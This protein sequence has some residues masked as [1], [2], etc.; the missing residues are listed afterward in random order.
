[1]DKKFEKWMRDTHLRECVQCQKEG[2]ARL[3][4]SQLMAVIWFREFYYE[5]SNKK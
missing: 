3:V 1:M 4:D 5:L 2:K